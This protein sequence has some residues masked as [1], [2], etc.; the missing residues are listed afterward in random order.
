MSAGTSREWVIKG[1]AV[2][3]KN[4]PNATFGFALYAKKSDGSLEPALDIYEVQG[5]SLAQGFH[6]VEGA[7]TLENGAQQ[8]AFGYFVGAPAKIT[9]DLDGRQVEAT[10]AIWSA[11][12]DVVV[13]WFDNTKVTGDGGIMTTVTA[14]DASG[15]ELSRFAITGP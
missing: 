6:A 1:E 4:S 8:P 12:S 13:F 15:K 7:A 9:G 5:D 10:T 3:N 11:N 2:H 14:L